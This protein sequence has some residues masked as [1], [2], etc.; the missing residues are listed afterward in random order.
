MRLAYLAADLPHLQFTTNRL[1]RGM[2]K[3]TVGHWN[4]LKRAAR[5]VKQHARW[6]QTFEMQMPVRSIDAYTDSD[7]AG[8]ALDRKSVSC[9]VIMMG[10][11]LIKFSVATQSTPALSSG[12]AEYVANVKGAS[13]AL[14]MRSMTKDFGVDLPIKLHTDSAASKGIASRIGLGKVRH[15][16]T[17]LLWLQHHVNKQH[18]S[19]IKVAGGSNV[20]DLGTKDLDA[21]KMCLC[22]KGMGFVELSGK[23]PKALAVNKGLSQA[24]GVEE[25][26]GEVGAM[27]A[28]VAR[29]APPPVLQDSRTLVAGSPAASVGGVFRSKRPSQPFALELN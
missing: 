20:A 15:L 5:Y 4:R 25:G 14:G 26:L 29:V 16:D 2:S 8:D 1:A 3:P 18:I 11:H 6:S 27:Q 12:E 13:M 23:H 9:A 10:K 17:A 22:M 19:M 21:Q 28:Q 24:P 7:W